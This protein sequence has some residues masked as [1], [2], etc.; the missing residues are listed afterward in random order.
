MTSLKKL[1]IKG[2]IWTIAG[3]GSSQILRFGSNLILTRLL[4]PEFFGLMAVVNTLRI[5]IELFSDLGI[6]QS[7]INT[8]RG[9]DPAFLNTAW[10]LAVIRGFM[11]WLLCLLIT[12]PMAHFYNE[13]RLL[14]LIPI[15]GLSSVIDG[16]TSNSR[17]ILHR[18]MDLGRLTVFNL[19]TQFLSLLTLIFLVYVNRSLLFLAL[20]VFVGSIY[21]TVGSYWLIPGYRDRFAWDRSSV[22]E[23]LSFGKWMFLASGMT[24]L[25]EQTDRLILAKLL[26]FKMLGI[27]TVAYTLA[28]I[29]REIIKQISYRVIFPAISNQSDLPRQ[30]LRSKILRQRRLMLIGFA[31]LLASLVTLGDMV[32]QLLYDSRYQEATWM[33]PILSCGIW[34]SVL[35]YTIS[36]A[37][38]AIG[39]ALYS[40]Q[41]NL[42]GFIMI[43]AGLPLAF[44][45]FGVIGA[46]IVIAFSDLP[47]YLVNLYALEREKLSCLAQDIQMTIFFIGLLSLFL[48]IR[49][50]LGFG[51]PIQ[52]LL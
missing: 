36:P 10:T 38:L 44:F 29:P 40:A 9:H 28:G 32:I 51:L 37:L 17:H 21:V 20:G 33:M 18:R 3:Y 22:D 35:F 13:D 34:F 12:W 1:A 23:I 42:A 5:G 24:F 19:S 47:L 48:S 46:I 43:G 8:K 25:N 11:I 39:K 41:S 45:H 50:F 16:F 7:I 49:Y 27:Y 2:T 4:T 52:N 6:S 26:S 15:V 14:W 31:I 30:T